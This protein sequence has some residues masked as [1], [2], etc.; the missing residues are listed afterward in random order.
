[1]FNSLSN[2]SFFNQFQTLIFRAGINDS[3]IIIIIDTHNSL[4]MNNFIHN[5]FIFN[6]IDIRWDFHNIDFSIIK[7]NKE[8][9]W[10]RFPMK[11]DGLRW[12]GSTPDSF[13]FEFTFIT[14]NP[15]FKCS[16]REKSWWS[17]FFP[18]E[19]HISKIGINS[20]GNIHITWENKHGTF[21]IFIMEI[22]DSMNKSTQFSN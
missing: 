1:M 20:G 5:I 14:L 22:S 12:I 4:F 15:T 10:D 6:E 18:R 7:S 11:T 21:L 16:Y 2:F 13:E 8:C 19:F 17:F 9:L 3:T